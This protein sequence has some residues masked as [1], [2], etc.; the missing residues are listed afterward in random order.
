MDTETTTEEWRT[1]PG[2]ATSLA[3]RICLD[4]NG[5]RRFLDSGKTPMNDWMGEAG[6]ACG[7]WRPGVG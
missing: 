1:G 2:G 5:K 4:R 7:L 3:L 6:L